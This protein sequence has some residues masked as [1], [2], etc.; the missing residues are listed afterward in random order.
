[1]IVRHLSISVIYK[2]DFTPRKRNRI[3]ILSEHCDYTQTAIAN[4]VG[5]SQKSVSR[6]INNRNQQ[7]LL[8]QDAKVNVVESVRL[9]R[10]MIQFFLETA[11]KIQDEFQ[12]TEEFG[13]GLAQ[14]HCND[15]SLLSI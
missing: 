11:K 6:I 9:P 1:M 2:I 3:L 4:I 8:L 13:I 14:S 7:A 12:F 10:K 5:F 15:S